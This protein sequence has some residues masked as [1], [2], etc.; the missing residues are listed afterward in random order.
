MERALNGAAVVSEGTWVQNQAFGSWRFECLPV[1]P[2]GCPFVRDGV[3]LGNDVS[4]I[5]SE[6]RKPVHA[7]FRGEGRNLSWASA[8]S[9]L[10]ASNQHP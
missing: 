1:H 10:K 2:A 3:G 8:Q 4:V 5:K 7:A 9:T 6:S